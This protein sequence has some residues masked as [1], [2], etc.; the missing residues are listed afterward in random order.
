[1]AIAWLMISDSLIQNILK[2]K[3]R[4]VK[5]QIM[6]SGCSLSAYWLGHYVGDIFF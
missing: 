1:M 2:E 4:N 6:I 3:A 5:H